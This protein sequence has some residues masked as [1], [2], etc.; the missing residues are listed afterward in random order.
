[1]KKFL[2]IILI[3]FTSNATASSLPDCPSDQ[4]K[5]YH[6]CFGTY[7]YANGDK[8]V[9]EFKSGKRHGQGTFIF[10][11]GH[12]YVG[13]FENGK[14][15]G[16]GTYTF[17]NGDEY[18]GEFQNGKRHG[19]GTF[20]FSNGNKYTGPFLNGKKHGVGTF[21]FING[22]LLYTSPS[23]RDRTRSRMPSSA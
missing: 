8:Y 16:D 4:S 17:S 1:M 10:S 11:N 5:R 21:S 15:Q 19:Q 9:G 14:R 20:S 6:N 3:L 13:E 12:K 2:F 22:C 18:V 7:N 23:P